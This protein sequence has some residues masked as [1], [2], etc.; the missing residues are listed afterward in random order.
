MAFTLVALVGLFVMQS[1]WMMDDYYFRRNQRSKKKK[2]KRLF[3]SCCQ[4]NTLDERIATIDRSLLHFYIILTLK[5]QIKRAL[6]PNKT[7]ICIFE[8]VVQYLVEV[9]M[10]IEIIH[11]LI[12]QMAYFAFKRMKTKKK[13]W[14]QTRPMLVI[15]AFSSCT[16]EAGF[17]G[18][19]FFSW[20]L[21]EHDQHYY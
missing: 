2:K 9:N 13:Q 4:T 11:L 17:S 6:M 12:Q 19:V 20:I 15:Q 8:D 1:F 5:K 16:A 7:L 3:S 10:K 14:Y 18:S 21:Q